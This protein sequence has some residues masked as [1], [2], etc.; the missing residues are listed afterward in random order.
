MRPFLFLVAPAVRQLIHHTQQEGESM[1]PI[2]TMKFGG[3]S[4]GSAEA[5]RLATGSVKKVYDAGE[6]QIVVVVSAM[7]TVTNL[8]RSG[9]LAAAG[10][11]GADPSELAQKM[12]QMHEE[13]ALDLLTSNLEISQLLIELR[14]LIGEFSRICD[15]VQVLGEAT[16]RAMDYIMSLGERMSIRLVAA[17]FREAGL[18][19]TAIESTRLIRTDD[20]YQDAAPDIELTREQTRNTLMPLLERGLIPIVTGFL[21]ATDKGI[22]TTLGRGGSD[23]SA[24]LIGACLD[25]AEVWIWTDVDGVMSAD[26]RVVDGA[27]T[28]ERMSYRE[29]SELAFFGARVLHPKTLQPL[30]GAK[31]QLWVR[32]T[33]NPDHPGTLIMPEQQGE[34]VAVKAVTG[35][36]GISLLVVEGKGMLGVPG[37]AARTFGT[38]AQTGTSVLLITQASSE[39]GICFAIPKKDSTRV[40]NALVK[41]FASEI[42]RNDI[43]AIVVMKDMTIVTAVGAGMR[44]TP[45]VA[46]QVFSAVAEKEINVVAIAQ[47][48]SECAISLI[49]SEEDCDNAV[50]AIHALALKNGPASQPLAKGEDHA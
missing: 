5:I 8:L 19:T 20:R 22:V 39:Q 34:D 21:G 12:L 36:H 10:E 30:D 42:S 26:P 13:V 49:V 43:E 38:V 31:T 24:S 7:A 6:N 14:A 32:N 25:S 27:H 44:R 48:S 29:V 37:I 16:P 2:I 33:F 28:I 4:V 47:G 18:P 9:I 17:A 23:Y 15:S 35:I 3:T 50:R 46:A 40:R 45:G 11:N 1:K 41:E